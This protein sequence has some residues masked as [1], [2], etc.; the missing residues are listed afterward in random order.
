MVLWFGV[1]VLGVRICSCSRK[2]GKSSWRQAST[3]KGNLWVCLY[4]IL[5]NVCIASVPVPSFTNFASTNQKSP[6]KPV[7]HKI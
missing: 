3:K 2:P 1:Q 5:P 6:S 7:E 4:P